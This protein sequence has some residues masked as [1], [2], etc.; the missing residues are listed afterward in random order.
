MLQDSS[1]QEPQRKAHAGT[2]RKCEDTPGDN[3]GRFVRRGK[4]GRTRTERKQDGRGQETGPE[5]Q[6]RKDH[7]WAQHEGQTKEEDQPVCP[8]VKNSLVHRV[9]PSAGLQ[10]RGPSR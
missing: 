1:G 8:K 7:E 5:N 6:R 4:Q 3:G 9:I 10:G 2:G